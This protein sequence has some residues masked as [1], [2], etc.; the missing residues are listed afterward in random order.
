MRAKTISPASS[1]HKLRRVPE[2]LEPSTDSKQQLKKTKQLH[3]RHPRK[4]S[5][6]LLERKTRE[7]KTSMRVRIG[8]R[9]AE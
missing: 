6:S 2:Q 1:Q 8:H 4:E 5:N 3:P 7:K 9:R